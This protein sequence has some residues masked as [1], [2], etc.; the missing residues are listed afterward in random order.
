MKEQLRSLENSRTHS[1]HRFDFDYFCRTCTIGNILSQYP[2]IVVGVFTTTWT[3][4]TSAKG[5]CKKKLIRISIW[6]NKKHVTNLDF[7]KIKGFPTVKTP[8]WGAQN[9]CWSRTP[10]PPSRPASIH[11]RSPWALGG[12]SGGLTSAASICIPSSAPTKDPLKKGEDYSS[13]F[14]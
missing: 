9:S 6:P 8:I 11:S 7:P 5:S 10:H 4:G 3:T 14:G 13:V 2:R 12:I 1:H